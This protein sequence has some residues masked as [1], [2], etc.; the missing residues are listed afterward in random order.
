MKLFGFEISKAVHGKDSEAP[1]KP[2]NLSSRLVVDEGGEY[3]SAGGS[4]AHLQ[5]IYDDGAGSLG[6]EKQAIQRY[7]EIASQPEVENAINDIVD[8]AII[9]DS[10]RTHPI[11]LNLDSIDDGIIGKDT[12]EAVQEAWGDVCKLIK[13]RRNGSSIFRD[14]YID[15][16][17]YFQVIID[18]KSPK[19]GIKELV[20]L[21]P[22]YIKLVRELEQK[23]DEETGTKT[24]RVV[25]EYYVYSDGGN[26]VE[27]E[28]SALV[29]S[30]SGIF[31][32][33][34]KYHISHLAKSIKTANQLRMMEDSLV[35]YRLARAPERRIFYID[36]GNL[37]KGKAEEYVQNI[38]NKYR[39]K[40]VY[41]PTSGEISSQSKSTSMLEDIWLPRREGGK[42]TEISTLPGGENLSQIEDVEF[43]QRKLY[44]ALNVPSS[45]LEGESPFQTG[46]PTEITREEL[47]Y[48]K[49][50]D[51]LR[52]QFVD[53]LKQAL[54]T[55]LIL[56][57]VITRQD[58]NNISD[59]LQFTYLE[60]NYFSELKEAEMQES[61]LNTLQSL[62]TYIGKF[63]SNQWIRKNVL[64]LTDDEIDQMKKEIDAEKASGEIDDDDDF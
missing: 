51:R 34:R 45:R 20:K 33:S 5:Y 62:D 26:H 1:N 7:R 28:K 15:G 46:R 58:W 64:K 18:K 42:G 31:D 16:K 40:M 41:D 35:I 21:D 44:K 14:F 11:S 37:P 4:A 17:T 52:V 47:K 32:P 19:K 9:T 22:S 60:D 61:R 13:L 56:T 48:K 27:I 30:N 8:A 59:D 63:Y 50:I 43:F 39:S 2:D 6:D 49:F 57:K 55:Q 24:S 29:T 36:V 53:Q 3:V 25:R 54:K 12:Q 23:V 10:D 38:M